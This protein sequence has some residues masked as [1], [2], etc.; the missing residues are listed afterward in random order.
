MKTSRTTMASAAATA[1]KPSVPCL[2]ERILRAA[3]MV[4]QLLPGHG[5]NTGAEGVHVT[6]RGAAARVERV[7]V[8]DEVADDVARV[9]VR[10]RVV[11]VALARVREP[12]A[13]GGPAGHVEGREARDGDGGRAAAAEG[14]EWGQEHL[15]G[16]RVVGGQV[17]ILAPVVRRSAG[18]RLLRAEDPLVHAGGH[19][20]GRRSGLHGDAS[21]RL[22]SGPERR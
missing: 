2:V 19:L 16:P 3:C 11:A 4:V 10:D 8:L 21:P 1:A 17:R 18:H 9:A 20:V 13:R 12:A 6:W 14:A 22:R 7:D 15:D 5:G